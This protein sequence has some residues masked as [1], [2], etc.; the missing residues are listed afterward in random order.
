V[1]KN[2]ARNPKKQ[3][4][5]YLEG[6]HVWPIS[7]LVLDFKP[8]KNINILIIPSTDYMYYIYIT[9]SF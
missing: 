1:E 9:I 6:C 7:S 2:W 3:G 8:S 5:A 4:L